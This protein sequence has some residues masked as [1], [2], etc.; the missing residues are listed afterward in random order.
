MNTMTK[1]LAGLAA[2][3]LFLAIGAAVFFDVVVLGKKTADLED[4]L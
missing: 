2:T 1:V 4:D 3:V